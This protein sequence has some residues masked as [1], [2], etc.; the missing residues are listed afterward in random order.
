MTDLE[1]KRPT[2][3][4]AGQLSAAHWKSLRYFDYYRVCVAGILLVSSLL[5]S[6]TLSSIGGGQNR[7]HVLLTGAYLLAALVSLFVVHYFRKR[8]NLQLSLQV[9]VDV[10]VLTL[11]MHFG[12]GL[13]S[14]LG[15]MLLVV[16]AGAGLVGQGRLVLF[17]AAMATLSVLFEQSYRAL[18][19]D[20]EMVDFF[21]AGLFC[22]GFFGVAISARLLARRVIANEELARR[23]GVDLHNQMLVSQRVLEEMQDGILVLNRQ[24]LGQAAQSSGGGASW[25]W[26]SV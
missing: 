20:F 10:V 22:A 9:L 4:V 16:L 13:R 12:G 26:Q 25:A 2:E 5:N 23:R 1:T 19:A 21:Q 15:A 14:G 3:N 17:Y 18:N 6:S 24:G 8:F 7:L 11:L